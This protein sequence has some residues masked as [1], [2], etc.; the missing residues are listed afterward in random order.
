[1]APASACS[2]LG[3][4][5]LR[6]P[7]LTKSCATRVLAH[8]IE[9]QPSVRGDSDCVQC[10]DPLNDINHTHPLDY[11][12]LIGW[13]PEKAQSCFDFN[14]LPSCRPTPEKNSSEQLVPAQ[15]T[16][17]ARPSLPELFLALAAHSA[18]HFSAEADRWFPPSCG[19]QQSSPQ[20]EYGCGQKVLNSSFKRL[21][22][23]QKG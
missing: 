20:H 5:A 9:L 17:F 2:P 15:F 7:A 11:K 19:T 21:S 18:F 14:V 3:A 16:T 22:A 10:T 8:C 23:D 4:A 12:I 1:M 6:I 13:L